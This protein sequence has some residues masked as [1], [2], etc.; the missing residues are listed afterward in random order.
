MSLKVLFMGTP[1]FARA[2]LEAIHASR[3]RIVGVVSQPD[4]PKGR[5]QAVQPTPVAAF[6]HAHALPLLQPERCNDVAFRRELAA[7]GADIAV[8]A[9]FGHI[10]GPKALAVPRLGCVNIHASLLPRWRGASPIS[11]AIDAGDAETGVAIMQMDAGMDT[12]PVFC[13]ARTPIR[14]DDTTP[15]L[16]DR[17]A[18]LG[19]GLIVEALDGI[20]AGTLVA[21]PQPTDGVTHAAKLE[22]RQADLDWREDAAALGRHIRAQQPWP[23]ARAEIDGRLVRLHP[24]VRV[25]DGWHH[26]EAPGTVLA[27]G[28]EGVRI[29]CGQRSVLTVEVLQAEGRKALHALEFARGFGLTAGMRLVTPPSSS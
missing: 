21:M 17:L 29:A 18:A 19:A 27:I 22:K 8:V 23:G 24:P 20:E 13:V 26:D 9:A 2:A 12:G 4:R 6:A 1:D 25:A 11:A 16:H 5:G 15:S 14:P 28:S 3:H 7:F 10:L